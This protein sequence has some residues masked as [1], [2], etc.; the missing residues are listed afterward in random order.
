MRLR[1]ALKCKSFDWYLQNVWIENFLPA[2]D[3]FFGKLVLAGTA[4]E[5]LDTYLRVLRK[6][7]MSSNG[8]WTYTIKFLKDHLFRLQYLL[9]PQS[10]FGFCLQKPLSQGGVQATPYGQAGLQL[11]HRN[12]S[13]NLDE[14]FVIKANGNVRAHKKNIRISINNYLSL[15][16]DNDKRRNLS[17]R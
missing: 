14:L 7:D 16:S 9:K 4:S 11:C 13:A 3:R 8:N 15:F 12:D 6:F 17:G 10:A 5:L 2:H 1:S